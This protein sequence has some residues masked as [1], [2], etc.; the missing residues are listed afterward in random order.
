MFENK[1]SF[2]QEYARRLLETYGVSVENSH[3]TERYAVLGEMVRDYANVDWGRT[4]DRTIKR[5]QK[6]L[7]YFSM[8]F[9]IG[10][11]L[12]NNM[13]N[14]GIYDIVKVGLKDFGINIH[15]LEE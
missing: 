7:I 10:R 11:L 12:V 9:L 4:H 3:I 2:K 8:E 1:Q 13:Q 6:A 5:K 15:E 14:M